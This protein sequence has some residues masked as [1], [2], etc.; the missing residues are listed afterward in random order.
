G[1]NPLT[2]LGMAGVGGLVLTCAGELSR[3]RA[4]GRQIA[5]G[6]D[7]QAYLA[8]QRSV[9][10]GY[11]TAAAASA[12]ARKL[13]VDMPI[14]QNVSPVLHE[15]RPLAEAVQMLLERTYKDELAG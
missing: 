3:N 7:P 13:G 9:A 10:E 12:L 8:S 2:F 15:G 6:V 1:A 5:M 14:P 11:Y 4:L